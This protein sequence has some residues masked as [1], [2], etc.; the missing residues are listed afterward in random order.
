MG[1][2]PTLGN[3]WPD[4]KC[5]KAF[6][7]QQE[8]APYRRLLADTL[9]WAAPTAGEYWLDLGCGS[10]PLTRAI[11]ERTGGE[12]AEVLGVDVAPVNEQA[13]A[14]LRAVMTPPPG[15]RIRFLCHDF[16]SGLAMLRDESFDHAISGLSISYAESFSEAQSCWTTD[17]YTR[18]L[19]ETCRIL[20]SGGRFVFSVNVPHPAWWKIGLLSL[21]DIFRTGRPLRFFK[22][23]LRM[24][25]YGAWLKQEA[26]RGRFHYLPADEVTNK[27]IES[28]FERVEHRLSYAGQAFVFRCHKP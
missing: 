13:Y 12:V 2:T 3:H 9:D 1:G 21:G 23:A 22:R 11:W 20:R 24:M 16:S 28:G 26:S 5:A 17:A 14:A 19:R 27:L 25:R 4:A 18:V 6:W 10:G 8:I 15:D 7:S